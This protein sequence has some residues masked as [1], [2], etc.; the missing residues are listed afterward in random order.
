VFDP[1]GLAPAW[2]GKA[3]PCEPRRFLNDH[4]YLLLYT[5]L[6]ASLSI[7]LTHALLLNLLGRVS[8]PIPFLPVLDWIHALLLMPPLL[9][10]LP[11][12]VRPFLAA[13]KFQQHC[14]I[15][16]SI[17]LSPLR[18][19][20]VCYCVIMIYI[21]INEWWWLKLWELKPL[22]QFPDLLGCHLTSTTS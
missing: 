12:P 21:V 10:P 11:R 8:P 14:S 22:I 6:S 15:R 19:Y 18:G 17:S 1:S 2:S 4:K 7:T 20:M 16:Y 5:S 3:R 13:N 9:R